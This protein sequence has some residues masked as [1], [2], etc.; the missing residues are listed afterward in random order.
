M[1]KVAQ[2][3]KLLGQDCHVTTVTYQGRKYAVTQ[4][5]GENH[6]GSDGGGSAAF[7]YSVSDLR[8][9]DLQE[10]GWDYSD[11]CNTVSTVEDVGLARKLARAGIR[12]AHGGACNPVLSDDE[13]R[14]LAR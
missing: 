4:G 12:L 7:A 9:A 5:T 14:R 8:A 6:F 11:W 3:E 13:F 10:D 1:D 2:L